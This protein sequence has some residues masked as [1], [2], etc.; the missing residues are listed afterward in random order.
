[1]LIQSLKSPKEG[2]RMFI[3]GKTFFIHL[4]KYILSTIGIGKKDDI[5]T[6]IPKVDT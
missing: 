4:I 3:S 6:A 1:M 2:I 5:Q